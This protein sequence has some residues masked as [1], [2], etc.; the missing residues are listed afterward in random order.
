M[1]EKIDI[2]SWSGLPAGLSLALQLDPSTRLHSI[3]KRLGQPTYA[4]SSRQ[5]AGRQRC[6]AMAS[7]YAEAYPEY[8]PDTR[9]RG[10]VSIAHVLPPSRDISRRGGF[11]VD[12]VFSSIL[13]KSVLALGLHLSKEWLLASTTAAGDNARL[14]VGEAHWRLLAISAILLAVWHRPWDLFSKRVNVCFG[15]CLLSSQTHAESRF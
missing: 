3:D 7:A 14:S 5:L 15:V 4:P 8:I 11:A 2:S 6:D 10:R 9:H 1:I 12:L 13:G